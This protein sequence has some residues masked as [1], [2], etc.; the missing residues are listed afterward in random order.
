[1]SLDR[2]SHRPIY[3]VPE[4][5]S[6]TLPYAGVATGVQAMWTEGWVME[7]AD[8][9]GSAFRGLCTVFTLTCKVVQD[10]NPWA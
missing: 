9:R 5:Q 10:G 2:G 8:C 7:N 1:M 3:A 4:A 6:E